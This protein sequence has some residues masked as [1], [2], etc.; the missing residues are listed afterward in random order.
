MN[1]VCQDLQQ[2][3]E[4]LDALV[5]PLSDKEW[6][7]VTSFYNWTI[8][9]EIAHLFFTD[10]NTLLT[11]E[12]EEAFKLHA[13]A[14]IEWMETDGNVM[15]FTFKN[16]GNPPVSD[17]L[18]KWRAVRER[19]LS[20][21]VRLNPKDRFSWYGPS[22]STKSLITARLMET[23]AHGQDIYDTLN[24]VRENTD[25]LRHIAHMGVVTYQWSFMTNQQ[26]PPAVSPYIELTAPSGELWCWGEK[27]DEEFVKGSAED[28][29][30][31][32][33][34]RRH[35]LDLSLESDGQAAD[36][37]LPIAQCFAGP[38]EPGPEPGGRVWT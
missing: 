37:W 23:W 29:C 5:A 13:S 14:M 12:D 31:L 7:Q 1:K 15:P 24:L 18:D 9:D 26:E 6:R 34:R 11:I 22:M 4:A 3:Y 19:L 27:N 30:L 20:Q 35:L 32:I 33:T 2:E 10:M 17:L 8:Y 36:A 28:F 25:R 21:T 16:M 38:A